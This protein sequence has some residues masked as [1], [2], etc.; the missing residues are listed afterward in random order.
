MRYDA[1]LRDDRF[2]ASP[3]GKRDELLILRLSSYGQLAEVADCYR[4]GDPVAVHV[5]EDALK[6]RAKDVLSGLGLFDYGDLRKI[7]ESWW[8]L[9]PPQRTL[10]AAEARRLAAEV[11]STHGLDG[12]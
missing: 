10:R 3:S 2:V 1:G 4:G 11:G 12:L 9:R 7:A 6:G 5:N 8:L